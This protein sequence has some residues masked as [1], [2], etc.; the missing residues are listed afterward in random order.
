MCGLI[1]IFDLHGRLPVD[2]EVLRSMTEALVHRGPDAVGYFVDE[3]VGLGLRRLSIIDLVTGDQPLTNEDESLVLVC[4]GEIFNYRELRADLLARGHVLRT[5]GDLEVLVHLY[6]ERGEQFLSA[7]NGQFALALY[8]RRRRRLL[9]ARDHFGIAPLHYTVAGGVLIFASEIKAILRHPLVERRVNLSGLDQ[10]LSFPG[11]VSPTTMFRDVHSLPGGHYLTAHDGVV[12][13]TE[14][15][16]LDYPRLDEA[17]S[18]LPES[19]YVEALRERL[20]RAVGYRL[21]ADVPV[22]LYLSGGM[23]SSL[24][25]A[26]AD[27]LAP[28]P[29]RHTFSITFADRQICEATFQRLMA[30]RIGSVHHE[31]HFDWRQIA[32]RLGTM[33]YQ[34]E[35]PLKETF[36]T[37]SLALSE[38]A[39]AAGVKVVLA[40]EGADELFA[41]Y[42]GYRFDRLGGR[43]A[44]PDPL[45]ALLEEELRERLWGD[46]TLFY[47]QDQ[48]AVLEIKQ[49]LYSEAVNRLFPDFDCLQLPLVDKRRLQGRHPLH[50]RSY[51]DVKLR[52]GEHLLSEHGDRMVMAN[53]VEGRYPFLD[54]SVVDLVRV[55]PPDLKLKGFV[56]KY[57][58][59]RIAGELVPAS[60]VEREKF[61]FRAPGSP[62]LLQQDLEWVGDLL[63]PARIRRQGYFNPRT[64]EHLK[65][66]YSSPGFTLHPHLDTDLLMVVLTFNLFCDRF[67]MPDLGA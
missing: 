33:I 49:D 20:A 67:G 17:P 15:W 58:L 46:R 9:L 23:D 25:A 26:L 18:E 50:Q 2:R 59:K 31:I 6:E 40:G 24:V 38:A 4:N 5:N 1:G 13:T 22:G 37:C 3:R 44:A 16:D 53:S 42:V 62:Y 21:Q 48:T 12:K 36:N 64:V 28:S 54:V 47:E 34:C 52:L 30:A 61:G 60:I 27:R 55:M 41:G 39:R 10:I 14:Y 32:E 29:P 57:V 43:R 35:C 56:E 63:S 66:R 7:L 51:L 11:L 65:A 8:D 45:D 19:H